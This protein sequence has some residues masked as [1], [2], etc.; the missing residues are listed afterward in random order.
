MFNIQDIATTIKLYFMIFYSF[1]II[2]LDYA[3]MPHKVFFVLCIF[4]IGDIV[5][6]IARAFVLKELSSRLIVLGMLRK[7]ALIVAIYLLFLASS[8]I[9]EFGLI[10]NIAV[11]IFISAELISIFENLISLQQK[12]RVSEHDALV[13]ITEM[14]KEFFIKKGKIE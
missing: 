6:G 5:T 9:T 11:G 13:K 7:I 3:E 10:A 1:I 4:M 12:E 14:L 8:I 2:L